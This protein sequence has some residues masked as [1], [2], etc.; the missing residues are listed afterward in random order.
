MTHGVNYVR[1]FFHRLEVIEALRDNFADPPFEVTVRACDMGTGTLELYHS[2]VFCTARATEWA[3]DPADLVVEG[4]AFEVD[5]LIATEFLLVSGSP[6]SVGFFVIQSK[7][8]ALLPD[9]AV[10]AER[11]RRVEVLGIVEVDDRDL[12]TVLDTRRDLGAVALLPEVVV[13]VNQ[14]R[15]PREWSPVRRPRAAR[16]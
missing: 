13:P 16:G 1:G 6:N 9:R 12:A 8:E 10:D 14:L 15:H 7:L 3:A 4:L 11:L 5:G 2:K